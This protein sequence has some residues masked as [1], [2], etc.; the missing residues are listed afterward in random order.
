ML[1][2]ISE[3]KNFKEE[4]DISGFERKIVAAYGTDFSITK[5][6]QDTDG[7]GGKEIIEYLNKNS[8]QLIKAKIKKFGEKAFTAAAGRIL[9]ITIDQLWRDHLLALDHLRH[10]IY[11]R[12]FGQKDP[13]N[14]Y[15]KEAFEYFSTMLSSIK[16]TYVSRVSRVEIH[17]GQNEKEFL[18]EPEQNLQISR[19]DPAMSGTE[20]ESEG[21]MIHKE[22]DIND[23]EDLG[24]DWQK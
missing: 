5:F 17:E 8:D 7:V 24:S 6:I 21:T 3:K 15:K 18:E 2:L 14:E 4:W 20:E 16:E 23:P 11:L 19:R 12:A 13:L 9:L 10:G 22:F 1:A